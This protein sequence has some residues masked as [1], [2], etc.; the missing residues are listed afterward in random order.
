MNP[1]KTKYQNY[2]HYKDTLKTLQ[3]INFKIKKYD[4]IGGSERE[5]FINKL[6][7]TIKESTIANQLEVDMFDSEEEDIKLFIYS[8]DK[9]IICG[10][11][12]FDYKKNTSSIDNI[13]GDLGCLNKTNKIGKTLLTIMVTLA[14]EINIE[15][16]ELSDRAYYSCVNDPTSTFVLSYANTLT[17]GKPYYYDL[18]WKY[19]NKD[20]HNI[21]KHNY[22]KMKKYMTSD[23]SFD[24]LVRI[25]KKDYNDIN[26]D[27]FSKLEQLYNELL[28]NPLKE[29]LNKLKYQYCDIFAKIYRTLFSKLKLIPYLDHLMIYTR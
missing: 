27:L 4:L 3:L 20:T 17:N 16:I 2:I 19:K 23:L 12:T 29:F 8:L 13:R 9:R 5:T 22:S 26:E 7:E 1:I 15:S 11:Q 25:I 6:N 18:G 21:V 14:K 10:I 24:K 28:D